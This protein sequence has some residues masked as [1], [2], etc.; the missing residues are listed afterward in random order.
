MTLS[1]TKFNTD[2][3]LRFWI[4]NAFALHVLLSTLM[5]DYGTLFMLVLAALSF[6]II[7]M[8]FIVYLMVIGGKEKN[9]PDTN[10]GV[11]AETEVTE[12]CPHFFGYL[13]GYPQNQ[14]IPDECFG[15]ASAIQCMNEQKVVENVAEVENTAEAAESPPQ[16]Q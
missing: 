13:V 15:C 7:G 1:P 3:S 14:P 5:A 9:K 10:G 16:Q 8:F 6:I 11:T 12:G 2:L 4:H